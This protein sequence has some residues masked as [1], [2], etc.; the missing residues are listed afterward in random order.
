LTTR[1]R[2]HH[3]RHDDAAG[4]QDDVRLKGDYYRREFADALGIGC[5]P[6]IVDPDVAVLDPAQALKFLPQRQYVALS[7]GIAFGKT[8]N[9]SYA[10]H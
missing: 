1:G 9:D 3:R 10:S 2:Q 4:R 7:I 6:A 5:S 8:H